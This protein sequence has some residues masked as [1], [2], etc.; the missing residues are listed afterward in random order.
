MLCRQPTLPFPASDLSLT[1]VTFD[2]GL[3]LTLYTHDQHGT[4]DRSKTEAGWTFQW[5]NTIYRLL[6]PHRHLHQT[7]CPYRC[8]HP[9]SEEMLS[10]CHFCASPTCLV[11]LTSQMTD[12]C[13][14]DCFSKTSKASLLLKLTPFQIH[15]PI[16]WIFMFLLSFISLICITLC[17]ATF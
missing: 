6:L 8:F 3:G 5:T 14:S 13:W 17:H 2:L 4:K 11:P 15:T 9:P 10:L 16:P 1:Q 12:K 7:I